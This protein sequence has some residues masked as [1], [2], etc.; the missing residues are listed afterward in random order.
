MRYTWN[1]NR[2]SDKIK[3]RKKQ[4][5][6]RIVKPIRFTPN[7]KKKST[8]I[9]ENL[10]YVIIITFTGNNKR[11]AL[12]LQ[13]YIRLLVPRVFRRYFKCLISNIMY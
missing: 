4:Q 7:L 6:T 9:N 11:M 1:R 2:I 8:R 3:E 5:R 10:R 13:K 12:K